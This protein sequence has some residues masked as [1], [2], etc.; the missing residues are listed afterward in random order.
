M[1]N[2]KWQYK[3]VSSKGI[4]RD[5]LK[6][7]KKILHLGGKESLVHIRKPGLMFK[8]NI[9][10]TDLPKGWTAEGNYQRY[11]PM[12]FYELKIKVKPK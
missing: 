1:I 2:N 9:V 3:S 6:D 10:I 7:Q 8:V 5:V 11:L 4:M 12:K